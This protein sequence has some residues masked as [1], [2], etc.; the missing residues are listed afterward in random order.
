MTTIVIH[1]VFEH[2]N[3]KLTLDCIEIVEISATTSQT[4]LSFFDGPQLECQRSAEP[5]SLSDLRIR[6]NCKNGRNSL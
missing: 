5:L 4:G 6:R 3:E 2:Y 1:G